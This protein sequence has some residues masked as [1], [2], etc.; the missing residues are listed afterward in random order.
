[1]W[2]DDC[3][4]TGTGTVR[5]P[6]LQ[7]PDGDLRTSRRPG[8]TIQ[9]ASRDL[10]RGD[11]RHREHHD[12]LDRRPRRDDA[13]RDGEAVSHD[14]T[15]ARSAPSR[16]ARRSISRRPR[17]RPAASR[18][19]TSRTRRAAR[20]SRRSARR[21]ARGSWSTVRR[22]RSR[23]TR[24]SATR[25]ATRRTRSITAAASTSTA[26]IR[27]TPPRP[28]ITNEPDP[29]NIAD[30]PAGSN[31][32]T[33]AYGSGGGIYV[34]YN[35]A[36]IITGNTIKANIAG[37]PS[38]VNQLGYGGGIAG[39]QPRHRSRTRRSAGTYITDNNAS[40]YG[41]GHRM[42]GLIPATGP[43][44]A[45]AR[46]HRQQHLRHQRQ[47]RRRRDRDG[48]DAGEDLQQHDSTTTTRRSTAA[49]IY[50]GATDNAGDV[51]EFVNNLVTT[52]QATGT[53]IAR[54]DLR[55]DGDQSR[56]AVQR[57]LG[58]HAD[59]RGRL[60]DRR[61]LHRGQREDLGRSAAT[62]IATG[63]RRTITCCRRAR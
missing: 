44:R 59:E 53:G 2:V 52:N 27:A 4:G 55:R 18:G 26:P 39:V 22:R 51:A 58:E 19:S 20:T 61:E 60:E 56:R 46:D 5:E 33:P 16:T 12:H 49:A 8:G 48:Y 43:T 30:P 24:S 6:L 14:R 13:R 41:G 42:S 28:V 36:P 29:G 54:R 35:S 47:C 25:S 32:R 7:D 40:D 62:S 17:A 1:M 9:R 31:A 23:G 10:P 63:F 50:F 15:S 11:P 37:S 38:K 57:H 21:S 3:A 34:G 45:V